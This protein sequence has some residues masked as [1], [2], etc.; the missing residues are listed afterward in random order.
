[1]ASRPER[2]GEDVG[3]RVVPSR[4]VQM[5]IVGSS[6][7]GGTSLRAVVDPA[8]A[9]S[10]ESKWCVRAWVRGADLVVCPDSFWFVIKSGT[11]QDF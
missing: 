6:W 1:M 3:W 7:P 10:S 9:R 5:R 8:L 2:F 4:P 11:R